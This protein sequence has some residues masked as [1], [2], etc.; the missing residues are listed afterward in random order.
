MF[1]TYFYCNSNYTDTR[2]VFACKSNKVK[3][4]HRR[5]PLNQPCRSQGSALASGAGMNVARTRIGIRA[6]QL[7]E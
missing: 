7:R 1:L 4:M 3:W 2:S 5:T 6:L